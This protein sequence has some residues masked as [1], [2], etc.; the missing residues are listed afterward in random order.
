MLSKVNLRGSISRVTMIS[1]RTQPINLRS[2]GP[3]LPQVNLTP[4]GSQEA[5]KGETELN[6]ASKKVLETRFPARAA[7]VTQRGGSGR[8]T[9]SRMLNLELRCDGLIHDFHVQFLS[10]GYLISFSTGKLQQCL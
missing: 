3:L 2:L 8:Q 1:Q 10:T 4:G 6:T 9:S 5:R 7:L